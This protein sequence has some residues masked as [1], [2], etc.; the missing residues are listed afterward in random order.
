MANFNL[1]NKAIEDLS[2]IWNHTYDKWSEDQADSY[3]NALLENCS[4]LAS[5]QNIGRSYDDVML[6]L[7]GLRVS[8][9][10]I[11]Y[12]KISSKEIEITRIL[13]ER[14]DLKKKM[15]E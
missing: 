11:L 4:L 2:N 3:Y 10:I 9:H 7:R 15:K 12:R 5:N 13:H 6:N 8:R 1:T 14:M